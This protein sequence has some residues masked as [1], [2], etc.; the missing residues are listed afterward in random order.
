MVV[1]TSAMKGTSKE[2]QALAR[3][4]TSNWIRQATTGSNRK[5]RVVVHE[6]AAVELLN[7]VASGEG[8]TERASDEKVARH[9]GVASW[10]LLHRI[11]DLDALGDEGTALRSQ[12]LGLLADCDTRITYAQH[13]GEI[14]RT[15][16]AL[17]WNDTQSDLVRK[18]R[19]GEGLWQV[20]ADRVAKVKNICSPGE[21]AVFRTD[22][23]GGIRA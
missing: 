13:A 12:A 19:K 23:L 11:A 21:E 3:L 20:G 18:L 9:D 16:Q 5:E 15:A 22:A 14:P 4:A 10:Y 2:A 8:L 7:V 17:G 6:E 1:E